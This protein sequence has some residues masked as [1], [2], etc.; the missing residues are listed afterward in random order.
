MADT[1]GKKPE[2]TTEAGKVAV[3]QSFRDFNL[4]KK[5]EEN[6]TVHYP[7]VFPGKG[8][9]GYWLK[10]RSQYSKEFREADLKAQRQIS[11]LIVA[12]GGK[13][14]E[15]DQDL[16]DD[17]RKRAFCKL[18]AEWNFPDE[19]NEDNLMDFMRDNEFVYDDINNLAAQDSLFFS[20]PA[21]N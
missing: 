1:S 2:I 18:V 17:I 21:K 10:I 6:P 20:E 7:F 3:V 4:K 13:A 16:I 15:I 8:D 5:L 11:A 19:L 14:E 9:T 12:N